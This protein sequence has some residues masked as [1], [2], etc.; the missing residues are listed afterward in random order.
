MPT[1]EIASA[2]NKPHQGDDEPV[3]LVEDMA[4]ERLARPAHD[5]TIHGVSAAERDLR[6]EECERKPRDDERFRAYL[7]SMTRSRSTVLSAP[8]G[9]SASATPRTTDSEPAAKAASG[10]DTTMG[11]S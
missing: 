11:A 9:S 10:L 3:V 1:S 7:T 5:E 2:G 8:S 6:C 4:D